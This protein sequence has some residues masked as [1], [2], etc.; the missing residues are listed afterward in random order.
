MLETVYKASLL[1]NRKEWKESGDYLL[2]PKRCDL[3]VGKSPEELKDK[4]PT[5]LYNTLTE[6][7]KHDESS[8]EYLDI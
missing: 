7:S 1:T 6:Y 8:I 3:I 5:D 2:N 4:L